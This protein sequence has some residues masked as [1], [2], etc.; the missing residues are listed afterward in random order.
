[1]AAVTAAETAARAQGLDVAIVSVGST[2][3]AL[4]SRS[5]AGVTETRP[6][7]YMFQDLFQVADRLGRA[8]RSRG[9]GAVERHRPAK[10]P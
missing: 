1:L 10:R 5:L 3:T 7:V 6:G 4:H 2:P 8:G 9:V